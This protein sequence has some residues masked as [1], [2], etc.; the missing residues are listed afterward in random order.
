MSPIN[1]S[2]R[3]TGP[4]VDSE[5]SEPVHVERARL[6]RLELHDAM[7]R[8]E[9]QLARAS[10]SDS[11]RHDLEKALSDLGASL[12]AHIQDV[13]GGEGLLS[14]VVDETPHLAAEVAS[15]KEEHQQLSAARFRA[16]ATLR[17]PGRPDPDVVRRRV[18]SLLGRLA[19]HRQRGAELV[20]DAYSVD[21]GTGD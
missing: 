8:L 11:W 20:Y 10:G 4:G 6:R 21:I 1:L 7:T 12:E 13:E 17:Q 18:T 2:E 3:S 14:R 5:L 15:L 19:L 9:T 16:L